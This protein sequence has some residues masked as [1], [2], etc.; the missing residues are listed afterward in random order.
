MTRCP[1]A[2]SSYPRVVPAARPY[3]LPSAS[4]VAATSRPKRRAVTAAVAKVPNT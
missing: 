3:A 2:P 4:A 1:T